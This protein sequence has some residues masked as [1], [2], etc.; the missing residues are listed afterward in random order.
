MYPVE[1]FIAA[2][3]KHESGVAQNLFL[4]GVFAPQRHRNLRDKC[5]IVASRFVATVVAAGFD[6]ATLKKCFK[7]DPGF[8][9]NSSVVLDKMSLA[10]KMSVTDQVSTL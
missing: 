2:S 9:I 8:N 6:K 4:E 5:S 7:R 10:Q 3:L 1:V